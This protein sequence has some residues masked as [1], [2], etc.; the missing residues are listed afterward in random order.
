MVELEYLARTS[1]YDA[2]QPACD[3][4][5]LDSVKH[6]II[7][8]GK[9][10]SVFYLKNLSMRAENS[11]GRKSVSYIFYLEILRSP[12]RGGQAEKGI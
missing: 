2:F 10:L 9:V 6:I 4:A 1:T 12:L 3:N 8:S 11:S 5:D 7:L